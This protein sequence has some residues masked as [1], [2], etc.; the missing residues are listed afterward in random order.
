MKIH[1]PVAKIFFASLNIGLI[2]FALSWIKISDRL[3]P[4]AVNVICY[5]D[6]TPNPSSQWGRTP[7]DLKADFNIIKNNN[8]NVIS[9]NTLINSILNGN[10]LPERWVVLTFDDVTKGQYEYARPLL[11]EYNFPAT[12]YAPTDLVDSGKPVIDE[13]TGIMTWQELEELVSDGFHVASHSHTHKDLSYLSESMLKDEIRESQFLLNTNLGLDA[14][15]FALPFGL[16]SLEQEKYFKEMRI[17][18]IAL[19]TTDHG[20]GDPDLIK[21]RRFEVKADTKSNKIL[22]IILGN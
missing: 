22:K 13:Y 8:I 6:I 11:K 16:Y 20:D 18:S 4:N 3:L 2:I 9:L 10:S 1:F 21:I 19:T 15:D 17:R 14:V 5:H 7:D 12:F